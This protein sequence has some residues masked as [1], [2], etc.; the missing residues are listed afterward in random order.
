MLN[1][2]L[3]NKIKSVW[4]IVGLISL[5]FPIALFIAL[6][7]TLETSAKGLLMAILIPI[8]IIWLLVA[9]I[10]PFLNYHFYSYGF[11]E[12]R[13][14]IQKGIIFR[15]Q[16]VIPICQIQDLHL[17]QGPIMLMMKMCSLNISTAGCNHLI[18]G[19]DKSK[20]EKII[21]ELTTYLEERIEALNDDEI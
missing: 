18:S 5:I 20:C 10:Y 1:H 15:H 16:I 21:K 4:L 2:K 14:Y 6:Y 3:D 17:E 7:L 19:I 12:K 8:I 9:L 13:V 11:D